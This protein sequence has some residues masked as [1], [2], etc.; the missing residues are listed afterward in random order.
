M[1][2]TQTKPIYS[3]TDWLISRENAHKLRVTEGI[4]PGRQ[5]SFR[6]HCGSIRRDPQEDRNVGARDRSKKVPGDR[7]STD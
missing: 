1:K 5:N 4:G 6:H 3:M 2:D 7:K